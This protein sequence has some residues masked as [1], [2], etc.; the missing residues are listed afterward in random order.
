M[1][2]DSPCEPKAAGKAKGKAAPKP[3]AARKPKAEPKPKAKGKAKA[4][5]KAVAPPVAG[6][7]ES[8]SEKGSELETAAVLKRRTGPQYDL[9]GNRLPGC[10]K[11]HWV[12]GCAR[13]LN[14]NFRPTGPRPTKKARLE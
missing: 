12:N 5:A 9:H 1:S 14:P 7:E 8:E 2:S 6:S 13:C 10:A 3:K 11:C 4:R